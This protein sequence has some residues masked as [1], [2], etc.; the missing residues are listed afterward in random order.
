METF[1]AGS[2]GSRGHAEPGAIVE[3]G[4]E[5][6][7]GIDVFHDDADVVHT[8]DCQAASL[9]SN[10][11][12]ERRPTSVARRAPQASEALLQPSARARS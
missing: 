10:A 5:F 11:R 1:S 9:A 3:L 4:E 6:N 8:L 2:R 12:V 7:G